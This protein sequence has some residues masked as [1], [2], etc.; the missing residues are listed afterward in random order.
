MTRPLQ[1]SSLFKMSTH[2]AENELFLGHFVPLMQL[3]LGEPI[4]FAID[5]HVLI[6]LFSKRLLKDVSIHFL[7]SYKHI[8]LQIGNVQVDCDQAV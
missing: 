3:I 8:T 1:K 5:F 4:N 7:F 6:Q 2:N